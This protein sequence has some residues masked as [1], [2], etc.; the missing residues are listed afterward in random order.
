M[1][2]TAEQIALALSSRARRVGKEW[3][4]VCPGHDDHDP[5]LSV[6]DADGKVLLKCR[7]GCSNDRLI[8]V[9]CSRG[10]WPSAEEGEGA[11]LNILESWTPI[12]PVPD[13][14]ALPPMAGAS[15]CWKLQ[16]TIQRVTLGRSFTKRV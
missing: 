8:G 11:N 16:R 9:L 3:I 5:S 14:T 15:M 13:G 4:T 6:T 12:I 7:V 2:L 1:Q 10:L